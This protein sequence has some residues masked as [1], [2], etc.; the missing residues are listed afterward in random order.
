MQDILDDW[1]RE[2]IPN[3]WKEIA[4]FCN[5]FYNVFNTIYVSSVAIHFFDTVV[6]YLSTD[7]ENRRFLVDIHYMFDY[8]SSPNYECIMLMQLMQAL[9]ACCM[10]ASSINFLITC[11]RTISFMIYTNLIY[12]AFHLK[13]FSISIRFYTFRPISI[14]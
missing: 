1:N 7:D 13:C 11:V 5:L 6:S 2:V 3:Y 10:E 4:R 8:K 9:T 14:F 12:L